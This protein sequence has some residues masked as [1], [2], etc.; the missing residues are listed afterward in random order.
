[1]TAISSNSAR[2]QCDSI[3]QTIK[4]TIKQTNN[5]T[6]QT[7]TQTSKQANKHIHTENQ[8]HTEF[9]NQTRNESIICERRKG[10]T[11]EEG[12]ISR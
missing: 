9:G 10:G 5:Y 1:M 8:N 7:N 6:K 3:N 12:R 11:V 2:A 4:Q